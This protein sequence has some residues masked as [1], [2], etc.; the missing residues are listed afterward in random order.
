MKEAKENWID[1]YCGDIENSPTRNNS[2]KAYQLDKGLTIEKPGHATAMQDAWRKC[3]EK[4]K[5]ILIR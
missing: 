4:K 1:N 3:Q 5:D 2:K